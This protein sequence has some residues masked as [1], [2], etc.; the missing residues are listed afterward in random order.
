MRREVFDLL[1]WSIFTGKFAQLPEKDDFRE[2]MWDSFRRLEKD[3]T[4]AGAR[5][6]ILFYKDLI[7]DLGKI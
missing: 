5:K 7:I 6:F 2:K 1:L 4:E 3:Q